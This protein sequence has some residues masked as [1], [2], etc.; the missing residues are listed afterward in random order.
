M[1]MP[2]IDCGRP[3]IPTP[4]KRE[5]PVTISYIYPKINHLE[6]HINEDMQTYRRAQR[7]DICWGLDRGIVHLLYD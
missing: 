1:D 7:P 2:A 6:N 3:L 4:W 5:D